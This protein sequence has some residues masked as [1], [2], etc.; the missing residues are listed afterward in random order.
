VAVD[1][2]PVPDR[3]FPANVHFQFADLTKELGFETGTF[4]IV[5]VRFVL[6]HIANAKEVLERAS[7]LVK[8]G[9]L[10]L[11]EEVD[12]TS[13]AEAGGP[14]T[15]RFIDKHKEIWESNE[16]DVD[17]GN[18]VE[19]LVK[20]FGDFPEVQVEKIS[21]PFGGNGP[22]V[23]LNKLGLAFRKAITIASGPL[24]QRYADRGLTP[25]VARELN[26]EQERSDN[27]SAMDLFIYWARRDFK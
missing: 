23:Q 5:H 16:A 12:I 10:L 25:E 27:Q 13:L 26:E 7:R 2:D 17:F 21:V 8:P 1:R 14:A 11:I 19:G 4:D 9:G 6:V 20:S 15:R 3:I 24:A 18:K 22:D